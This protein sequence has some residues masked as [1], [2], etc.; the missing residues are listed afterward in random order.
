[1]NERTYL[2]NVLAMDNLTDEMREETLG[3]IARLDA[4]NE[5][6]KGVQTKTQKENEPIANAIIEAL[7]NG[8]M[9]STDI[10]TAIGCTV[11]KVNGIALNL[12][13]E[14]K[15]TKSKV[16]VKG[17][18]EMTA[19]SLVVEVTAEVTDTADEVSAE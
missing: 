12:V 18:G 17:K 9:V 11:N 10:A 19:Y 16:K 3:R 5:K 2:N 7:A 4:K 15:L 8:T 6:R 14:G 1:M 13:K